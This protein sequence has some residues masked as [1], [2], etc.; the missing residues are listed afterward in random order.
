LQPGRSYS[1]SNVG[2][3]R[4][5]FNGK[6]RDDEVKGDGMQLDYG[7]R[8]Y[9]PRLGRFLSMDPVTNEFPDL[10]PYQFASNMPIAAID[11]DGLEA[12]V[13]IHGKGLPWHIPNVRGL[14]DYT[15]SDVYA[16]A[17]RANNLKKRG[18]TS[19]LV[20]SGKMI[21]AALVAATKE[22]GSVLAIVT[23]TH[24]GPNG[25]Y[26][27][28]DGGFY[29]STEHRGQNASNIS[30]IAQLVK[31]GKIKFE[32]NAIWVFGS[33][34]CGNPA[35]QPKMEGNNIAEDA[36]RELGITTYG[37]TDKVEPEEKNG[38]ETGRLTTHG[39]FIKFTPVTT[40]RWGKI[41]KPVKIFG[42]TVWHKEEYAWITE[43]IV[44]KTDVGKV[45]DPRIVTSTNPND[46]TPKKKKKK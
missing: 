22:Q 27:D 29:N 14:T 3:Y 1:Q 16:F 23:Y 28:L 43:V 44:Q 24:S 40:R 34:N 10:S 17:D 33:C 18:F 9:D 21:T 35:G 13:A 11:L 6:E 32:P 30:E 7:M 46:K 5:G 37:A 36:A 39:H 31:E 4:Y 38:K 2:A 25:L 41:S 45:L 19:V 42:I 26:L 15:P 12:K 20:H 8:I